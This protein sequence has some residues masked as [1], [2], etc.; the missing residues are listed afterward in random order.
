MANGTDTADLDLLD[1]EVKYDAKTEY[2]GSIEYD[3]EGGRFSCFYGVD[4]IYFASPRGYTI[5]Y[6]GAEQGWRGQCYPDTPGGLAERVCQSMGKK[7]GVSWANTNI[8]VFYY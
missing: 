8:Y 5:D 4:A 7:D 1:I 2:T 3:I 6:F